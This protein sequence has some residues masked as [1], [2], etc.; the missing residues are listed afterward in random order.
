MRAWT[1]RQG[2]TAKQAAVK[3]HSDLE[4]G[5]IRAE[6]MRYH[7]LETYGGAAKLKEKGLV[8]LEGKDYVVSDG[9]ILSIRFN[10]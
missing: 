3:V 4:R 2:T 8:S 5:F 10:V 6:A 7:D 1:V 9:D